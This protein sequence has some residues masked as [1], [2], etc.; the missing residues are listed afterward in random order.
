MYQILKRLLHASDTFIIFR[1]LQLEGMNPNELLFLLFNT[2]EDSKECIFMSAPVRIRYILEDS[3]Y[4][5]LC[6][7]GTG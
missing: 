7:G 4:S 6:K 3:V 2:P 5:K 1:A